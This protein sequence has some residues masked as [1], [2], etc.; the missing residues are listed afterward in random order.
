MPENIVEKRDQDKEDTA[1][2]FQIR[3]CILTLLYD[4]F[5]QFPLATIG[6]DQLAD[7]CGIAVSDLNWNIVYLEK[8]GCVELS[9]SYDEPPYI[10]AS[11]VL[12]AKGIDLIENPVEFEIK[13]PTEKADNEN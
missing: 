7:E 13:F 8:S 1:A 6:L 9:K 11:A 10:A 12:T 3:R 4:Y 2:H 5:K